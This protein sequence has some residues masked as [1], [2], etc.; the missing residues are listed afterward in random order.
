VVAQADAD[1]VRE[2]NLRTYGWASQFIYGRTQEV[3]QR[4]RAQAKDKPAL[5][6]RPRLQTNVILEEADPNDPNVGKEHVKRGW[7]R[8][9]MAPG[10]DGRP[11]FHSYQLIDPKDE[12]SVRDAISAEEATLRTVT[13]ERGK[14]DIDSV[15]PR[16]INP[17]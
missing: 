9:F 7:P 1:D 15:D 13:A 11:V 5:V 4:V 8:G 12:K 3:V 2:F 10:A 14:R 6:I 16:T 17:D